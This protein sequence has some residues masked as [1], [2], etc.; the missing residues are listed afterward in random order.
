LVILFR[1]V[2][3]LFIFLGQLLVFDFEF[4]L[5][6]SDLSLLSTRLGGLLLFRIQ[7]LGEL[8]VIVV[9][10]IKLSYESLDFKLYFADSILK[11]GVLLV[12][13]LDF[14]MQVIVRCC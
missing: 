12:S 9:G 5:E 4:G 10:L 1:Q 2:S 8:S 11:H 7:L 13:I 3:E 14:S 6:L